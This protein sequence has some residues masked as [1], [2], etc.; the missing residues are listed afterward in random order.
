[1]LLEHAAR[2]PDGSAAVVE[3]NATLYVVNVM[4]DANLDA[5]EQIVL[6]KV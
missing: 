3:E 4:V 1:M 2:A 5:L 6:T